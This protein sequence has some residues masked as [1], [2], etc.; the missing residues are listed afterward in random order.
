MTTPDITALIPSKAKAWVGLLSSL[1]TLGVPYVL[2]VTDTLPSPWPIVIGLVIAALSWLGIYKAPY[3]PAGATLAPDTPAVA[4]AAA[5]E[6]IPRNP[7]KNN[8]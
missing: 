2:S 1:L 6:S 4:A 7:W 8:P 5:Q 3:T